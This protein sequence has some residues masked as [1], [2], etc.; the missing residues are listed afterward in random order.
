MSVICLSVC[1]YI[2][3]CL[4]DSLQQQTSGRATDAEVRYMYLYMY[5]QHTASMVYLISTCQSIKQTMTTAGCMFHDTQTKRKRK[6]L[7]P[8]TLILYFLV[9]FSFFAASPENP[10]F[11]LALHVSPLGCHAAKDR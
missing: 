2:M 6:L 1:M 5:V 9:V 11:L 10:A 3:S 8:N 7:I 4:A